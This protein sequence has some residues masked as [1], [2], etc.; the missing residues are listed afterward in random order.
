[1]AKT[2][3]DQIARLLKDISERLTAVDKVAVGTAKRLDRH[4]TASG[5][6]HRHLRS[7]LASLQKMV[8]DIYRR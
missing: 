3:L 7:Q 1:M 6:I 2:T 5:E 8:H 4:I